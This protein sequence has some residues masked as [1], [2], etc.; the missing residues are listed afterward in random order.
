MV[1]REAL[2]DKIF[3]AFEGVELGGGVGLYEAQAIDYHASLD[4]RKEYRSQD[5]TQKWINI[6][7]SKLF[8]YWDSPSF[9]D[10]EG[11]RFHLPMYL[12]I[13]LDY[14]EKEIEKMY[15]KDSFQGNPPDIEYHLT[16]VLKYVGEEGQQAAEMREFE[17]ERYSL[18]N[19]AQISCIIEFLKYNTIGY[20]EGNKS[21]LFLER[22]IRYWENKLSLL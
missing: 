12:L 11:M 13:E 5:E 15:E 16:S 9:F 14:F 8:R 1:K 10:A 2:I 17:K 21:R 19:S 22:A 20:E 4:E 6:P 7:V 18:L 3:S